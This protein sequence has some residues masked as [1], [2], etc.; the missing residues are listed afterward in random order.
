MSNNT[1]PTALWQRI[2]TVLLTELGWRRHGYLTDFA[3]E[4]LR[5]YGRDPHDPDELKTIKSTINHWK[6]SG[7]RISEDWWDAITYITGI[8]LTEL[9]Q[10]QYGYMPDSLPDYS[11]LSPEEQELVRLYRQL[12]PI[13]KDHLLTTARSW[14]RKRKQKQ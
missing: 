3:I 6:N 13:G 12:T 11:D 14:V 5:Y 7:R 9:F 2:E 1:K 4:L 8:P 10:L